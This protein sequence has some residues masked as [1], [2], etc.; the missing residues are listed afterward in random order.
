MILLCSANAAFVDCRN[1]INIIVFLLFCTYRFHS[2]GPII[3]SS[4]SLR[5]F[6]RIGSLVF[7]DSLPEIRG[8]EILKSDGAQNSFLPKF[9]WKQC[10]MK[11]LL[12]HKPHVLQFLFWSGWKKW[13]WPITLQDSLKF[14][15]FKRNWAIRLIF[16]L[17]T[18]SFLQVDDI[19]FV[20][21]DYTCSKHP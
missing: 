6:L 11:V 10:R 1:S 20:G 8:L 15:I 18:N 12:I 5:V 3:F 16:Y 13:S 9:L 19:A 17:Q 4:V 2:I 14:N 7:S 21:H